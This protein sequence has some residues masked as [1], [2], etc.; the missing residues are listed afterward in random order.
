VTPIVLRSDDTSYATIS[1]SG[2]LQAKAKVG[3]FGIVATADGFSNEF[4]GQVQAQSSTIR[5]LPRQAA[6]N[7]GRF[8]RFTITVRDAH[9]APIPGARVTYSSSNPAV[10]IVSGEEEI[11]AGDSAVGRTWIR[12]TSGTASDSIAIDVVAIPMGLVLTPAIAIVAP[13]GTVQLL[14]VVRDSGNYPVPGEPVTWHSSNPGLLSVS[15]SGLVTSAGPLGFANL[16]AS[17]AGFTDTTPVLVRTAP[18]PTIV[19]ATPVLPQ[20]LGIA[21]GATG[22]I[23]ATTPTGLV[24][25]NL[26]SYDLSTPLPLGPQFIDV[27]FNPTGTRAFAVHDSLNRVLVIDV[28]TNQV[29]DSIESPL[30]RLP[31]QAGVSPDGQTLAVAA[32]TMVYFYDAITLAPRDSVFP[33]IGAIGSL[34]FHPSQPLLYATGYPG[35]RYNPTGLAEINY[36][37]AAVTRYLGPGDFG[38]QPRA[39]AVSADGMELYVADDRNGLQVCHLD[40]GQ[41]ETAITGLLSARSVAVSDAQDLIY[42]SDPVAGEILVIDRVSRIAIARLHP[43]GTPEKIALDAAGAT[44][45]VTND[46]G[47]ITFIR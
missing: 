40:T 39:T 13:G 34:S 36:A 25:G 3:L 22:A 45:A 23:Y 21:V 43:G 12:A 47:W 14:A 10:A 24:R 17:A 33:N 30:N 31:V 32:D 37:T 41:M 16:T 2:L 42:L 19:A 28:A 4:V 35:G 1:P 5:M 8:V 46:Q 27:A 29:I 7:R 6:V 11:A 15:S 9:D 20:P 18:V 44:A 38:V 26:P